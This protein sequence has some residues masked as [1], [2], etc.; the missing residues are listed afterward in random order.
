MALLFIP[1]LVSNYV[2]INSMSMEWFV[3]Q[4]LAQAG[5]MSRGEYEN[6]K[7][8]IEGS[9]DSAAK[10]TSVFIVIF[11]SLMILILSFYFKIVT[12]THDHIKFR[13]WVNFSVWINIPQFVNTIGFTI[14]FVLDSNPNL[15]LNLVNYASLNQ[16]VL[17]LPADNAYYNWAENINV[18]YIWTI[19][20]AT[21]G[22]MK[23][24]QFSVVKA[25]TF[26]SLP[27]LLLF[28]I[29]GLNI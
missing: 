5:E 6:T 3:E 9:F 12:F 8:Y 19:A 20:L 17:N 18:F 1:T 22:L 16:L 4:S 13:E 21:V 26:S 28:G 27:Y 24:C 7:K 23:W 11:V 10:L 2:F 14:L 15:P 25:L 29:W